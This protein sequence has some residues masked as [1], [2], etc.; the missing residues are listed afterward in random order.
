MDDISMLSFVGIYFLLLGGFV[1]NFYL[2]K[3]IYKVLDVMVEVMS[4]T[5]NVKEPE[6]EGTMKS[7]ITKGMELERREE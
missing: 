6:R 4:V 7:L 1:Y 5:T 3:K 2:S